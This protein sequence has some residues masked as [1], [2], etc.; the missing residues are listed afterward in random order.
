MLIK[1]Y[2]KIKF[3]RL[4]VKLLIKK[5]KYVVIIFAI[6]SDSFLRTNE[7][8]SS[9]IDSLRNLLY[10]GI[11]RETALDSLNIFITDLENNYKINH[12]P[13]LIA[14]KGVYKSVEAKYDFWPWDKFSAVNNGLELLNK[15]V[16]LD[17]TSIEIR[18]LRFAVLHNIPS[19]LGYSKEAKEDAE[20]LYSIIIN[21]KNYGDNFLIEKVADYLIKSERLNEK[22]NQVL[23]KIYN[24]S[25]NK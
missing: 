7:L 15:A 25:L 10:A 21:P 24:L 2:F 20:R 4:G 14:Y 19:I 12:E 11:E 8:N 16:N 17:S 13:L 3:F 18:F 22:Q 9:Q 1:S 5:I 6:L 23:G